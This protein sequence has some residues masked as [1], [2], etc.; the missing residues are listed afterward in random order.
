MTEPLQP[1]TPTAHATHD[2]TWIAALAARDHGLEPAEHAQARANLET[3][4]ACKDVYAD[5][6]TLAAAV[7]TAAVPARPRSYTLTAADAARLRPAGWR[8]FLRAVGSARD[9]ITFPLAM[10]LTTIGIAG[11]LVATLPTLS[12][13]TAAAPSTLSAVGAAVPQAQGQGQESLSVGAE[14]DQSPD[15][16]G[17]VFYGGDDETA[18][19][20]DRNAAAAP[21]EASIRDDASGF[22]VLIVLA[23]TL[24]IMGLGLFALRWTAR[25]L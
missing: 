10:G 14:T 11:L 7:P 15:E 13:G 3:C 22:S 17:G 8:R 5:L 4:D 18:A 20:A 21:L 6:V 12:A 24:L 2:P 1:A 25:R 23:G 16:L 19:P 9:G